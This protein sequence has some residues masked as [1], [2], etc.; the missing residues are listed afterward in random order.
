MYDSKLNKRGNI[1]DMPFTMIAMVGLIMTIVIS[2]AILFGIVNYY[3]VAPQ[4]NDSLSR[5]TDQRDDFF[6]LT[7]F[8]FIFIFALFWIG[9]YISAFFIRANSFFIGLGV[10]LWI[11]TIFLSALFSNMFEAFIINSPILNDLIT[12]GAG[13]IADEMPMGFFLINHLPMFVAVFG[14]ILIFILYSKRGDL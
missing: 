5:V 13:L 8:L 3:E 12:G 2:G 9:A 1:A 11:V 4:Y 7:D 6:N 10:V 14:L